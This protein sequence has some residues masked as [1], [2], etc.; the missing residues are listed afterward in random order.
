MDPDGLLHVESDV[1]QELSEE[2]QKDQIHPCLGGMLVIMPE[3]QSQ[4]NFLGN[5]DDTYPD[6]RQRILYVVQNV[7]QHHRLKIFSSTLYALNVN[8]DTHRCKEL[9]EH[10]HRYERKRNQEPGSSKPPSCPGI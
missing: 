5:I 3:E 8:L 6:W 10:A 2:K 4:D 9:E 1:P 7:L